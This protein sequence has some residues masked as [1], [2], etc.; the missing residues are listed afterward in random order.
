MFEAVSL[1]TQGIF[2]GDVLF[3]F[4]HGGFLDEAAD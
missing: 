3:F 4:A 1:P 2:S